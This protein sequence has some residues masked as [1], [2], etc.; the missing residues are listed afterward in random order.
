MGRRLLAALAA[1][2]AVCL[3]VTAAAGAQWTPPFDVSGGVTADQFPQVAVDPSGR[4]IVVWAGRDGPGG[5]P[6]V[7][8]RRIEADGTLGPIQDV[9]AQDEVGL[10][11]HVALDPAGNAMVSWTRVD[12]GDAV[13]RSRRIAAD[14]TLGEFNTLS[15]AGEDANSSQVTVDPAGVATVVW[16]RPDNPGHTIQ[17]R[18]IDATGT[19]GAILEISDGTTND[20]SFEVAAGPFGDAFVVWVDTATS[21]GGVI[22]GRRIAAG[23]GLGAIADLSAIGEV[24][25]RPQL[26]V[27]GAGL[28]IAAWQRQDGTIRSRRALAGGALEPIADLSLPDAFN[29]DVAVDSDGV[30]TIVWTRFDGTHDHI[31]LRR[32]D[33]AGVLDDFED[34]STDGD[35]ENASVALDAEGN[36]TV[37][38]INFD[39]NGDPLI[40]SRTAPAAGGLGPSLDVSPTNTDLS[41]PALATD[42]SGRSI[43]VWT[44][45]SVG[46]EGARY[47]APPPAPVPP[48]PAAGTGPAAG[49][50][51]VVPSCPSVTLKRLRAFTGGQPRS[52]RGR[53]KGIGTRLTLSRGAR[54]HLVSV[55]LSYRLGGRPRTARLRSTKLTTGR[56]PKLRLKLP[57]GL[58]AK[59][60]LGSRVTLVVKLRARSTSSGC[61]FGRTKTFRVTT[62]LIWVARGSAI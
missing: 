6:M 58:A 20:S 45:F 24:G 44:R 28:P 59:L 54:L 31:E 56:E 11:A 33:P 14:G 3:V 26:A 16:R 7:H 17:A 25:F 12:G 39:A 22:E 15:T 41:V 30:A 47:P 49:S 53:V 34:L 10:D 42:P 21:G 18:R 40:R 60:A 50:A 61:A 23:G 38:W 48:P 52:K 43:A 2:L 37:V 36:A 1:V 46:V 32:S 51:P 8:S 13:V 57:R 5:D 29:V 9:T 62:R 55:K 19:L 27:D 35:G 4:A